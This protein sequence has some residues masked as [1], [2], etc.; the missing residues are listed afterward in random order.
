MM[1]PERRAA[2]K[3][4]CRRDGQELEGMER[5]E[6]GVPRLISRERD[7]RS[8]RDEA[9]GPLLPAAGRGCRARSLW[10]AKM[11]FLASWF[12]LGTDGERD[13]DRDQT[14]S[15]QMDA[16]AKKLEW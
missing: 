16:P 5:G 9:G 15:G 13:S 3:A 7:R 1:A 14:H 6:E 4:G 11:E 10:R 8:C 12:A 2:T